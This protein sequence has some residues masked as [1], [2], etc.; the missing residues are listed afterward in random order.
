VLTINKSFIKYYN[1]LNTYLR[2]IHHVR[3]GDNQKHYIK[4]KVNKALKE[5]KK[6]SLNPSKKKEEKNSLRK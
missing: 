5:T 1:W 4:N 6:A 3:E 2:F